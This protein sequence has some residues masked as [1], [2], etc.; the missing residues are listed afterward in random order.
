[1][2]PGEEAKVEVWRDNKKQTVTITVG[3]QKSTVLQEIFGPSVQFSELTKELRAQYNIASFVKRGVVV[4]AGAGDDSYLRT[5]V[6]ILAIN[7]KPVGTPEELAANIR[8]GEVN[9]FR[10]YAHGRTR[11]FWLKL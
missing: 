1:L 7:N 9:L 10:I 8:K 5:G 4:T 2:K 11:A 3:S 6:V